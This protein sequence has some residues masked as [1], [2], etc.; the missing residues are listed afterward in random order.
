MG[1][2]YKIL[3]VTLPNF[4][5]ARPKQTK[6]SKFSARACALLISNLRGL[7]RAKE[8]VTGKR[9]NHWGNKHFCLPGK[10][11]L[12]WSLQILLII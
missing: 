4:P 11:Q 3:G 2:E 8:F 9:E 5:C 10:N 12:Q 1:I 7:G 6:N